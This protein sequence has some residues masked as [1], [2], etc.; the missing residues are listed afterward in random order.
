MKIIIA[1]LF[2][3]IGFIYPKEENYSKL[4][5]AD[6]VNLKNNYDDIDFYLK[7]ELLEYF[8]N[9]PKN[10]F[11]SF[12]IENEFYHTRSMEVQE[13]D[14]YE[15]KCSY[16]LFALYNEEGKL[17]LFEDGPSKIFL[18]KGSIIYAEFIYLGFTENF[19]FE[20]IRKNNKVNLPFDPIN[21]IPPSNFDTSSA[22]KDPLKPAE[23]NYKKRAGN[24]LY[25][26]SNNPE[27]LTDFDLNKALIRLDISNKEVFF[28]FEH[29]TE[30]INVETKIYSG[31]QVRN[32]GSSNLEVKIKNIGF[33]YNGPGYF[34][35]EKQ[36]ID[37]YNL[38]FNFDMNKWNE[39]Q[40]INFET[41]MN[42]GGI[43]EPSLFQ[44]FTCI[45]PPGKYIYVIGGT[46]EDS[47]YN[48]NV[49]NTAN[50]DVRKTIINGVVLFEVKGQAE[51]AYFIYNDVNIPKNDQESYQGYVVKRNG[52]MLGAQY[53][54]YDNCLGVVDNSMTW[55]FNDLT[56]NQYLPVYYKV[57]YS[58]TA[59]WGN[60]FEKI[61][62]S[63]HKV[64]SRGWSTHLNPHKILG[65]VF[66]KNNWKNAT[67]I[68]VVGNYMTKFITINEKKEAII[69]DNEHYDGR[70][71]FSNIGNWMI[72]YI[73]NYNFVNRGDIDRKITV[74]MG[75]GKGGAIACFVR[76]SAL[77][78]VEGTQKYHFFVENSTKEIN[79]NIYDIFDYTFIVPS[80]SVAQIYVEYNLLANSYGN[81]THQIYLSDLSK[82]LKLS[83]YLHII[84][85]L[86]FL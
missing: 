56:E 26:N 21:I 54:G 1:I 74:Q 62:T 72:D 71:N 23:V 45:V 68:R 46:T 48:L 35:G 15:L 32:T 14:T 51:G 7:E 76:N 73:D 83:S 77:E 29:S 8:K 55:E 59:E 67:K 17:I 34:F 11:E 53:I 2:F 28:T 3:I 4:K 16:T 31:F 44:S 75:L 22:L 79:D 84:I 40:R 65:E 80:H 5:E 49:F 82:F 10:K 30:N 25:I 60:P 81:L 38:K 58:S 9:L 42:F 57:N 41:Y 61:K 70:G 86:L 66:Y 52:V 18:Y 39:K 50:I 36:W 33:Q 85:S 12:E 69:I 19:K 27:K 64:N 37:F 13:T 78:I 47:Y 63:E 24:Y 20:I 6:N 43:Y